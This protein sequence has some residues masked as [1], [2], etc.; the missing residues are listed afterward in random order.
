VFARIFI[1]RPVLAIVVSLVITI[2]GGLSI[3]ALSV[4][5]YPE[6]TPPQIQVQAIYT[7]ANAQVVEETVAA[8]IEQQVNGA[9]NMIYMQSKSTN[10]R[11]RG[12]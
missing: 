2:A 7:G 4:A 6:I 5:Q 9:E 3:V 11:G 12:S 1:H 10:E 8:P